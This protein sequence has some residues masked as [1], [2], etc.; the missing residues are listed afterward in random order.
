MHLVY[1]QQSMDDLE[2]RRQEYLSYAGLREPILPPV[3]IGDCEVSL[4]R[5]VGPDPLWSIM[6]EQYSGG[7]VK[8]YVISDP[9]DD[10]PQGK[11]SVQI[12]SSR[13][14]EVP[15]SLR[16][17]MGDTPLPRPPTPTIGDVEL[18]TACLE[19]SVN[20]T[21]GV[22]EGTGC[23]TFDDGV[24]L[25]GVMPERG[26][27]VEVDVDGQ[28]VPVHVASKFYLA[29]TPTRSEITIAFRDREGRVV[30]E[31]HLDREDTTP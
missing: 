18:V 20:H 24:A 31:H 19:G 16:E 26:E 25:Y 3:H 28:R 7:L 27:T 17:E 30:D 9:P 14:G 4:H 21:G 29:A 22:G 6:Q 23:I 12:L 10:E 8:W 15:D 13:H 11:P 2:Q 1:N 5:R